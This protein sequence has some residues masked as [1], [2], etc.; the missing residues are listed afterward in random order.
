MTRLNP[1]PLRD[2]Q[3]A[4]APGAYPVDDLTERVYRRDGVRPGERALP[5]AKTAQGHP[6]W[7]WGRPTDG[8]SSSS[9][10]RIFSPSDLERAPAEP[11]TSPSI[12][13]VVARLKR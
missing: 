7:R 10:A 11:P 8:P 13:D 9:G 1:Y 2:G 5:T 6:A 4:P 12:A 3:I